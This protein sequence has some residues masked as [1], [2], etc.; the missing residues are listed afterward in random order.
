VQRFLPLS[1]GLI[2]LL[3]LVPA[4]AAEEPD[5]LDL[6]ARLQP[7]P[8]TARLSEPGY[9]VWCGSMVRGDDGKYH[10]FYSHWP[11]RLGFDAWVSH[12]EICHAV[13]DQ[14]LGPYQPKDVALPPRGKE[15]WDG[16]CTHDPT[17]MKFGSKY[18][19]Y[20]MGNTS[21]HP[22]GDAPDL[23][24]MKTERWVY[25]NN[26]RVG[27]AVADDPN[28]PWTRFDQPLIAPTPGFVDALCCND[29]TVTARPGGGYLMIY[30]AVGDK[31][32]LP[33]GGPVVHVVATSD[34]PTG[35]F[36]KE[37]TPVFLKEGASFPAEDP[38]VFTYR[39]LY[40]TLLKDQGGYYTDQAGKGRSLVLFESQDGLHWNLAKHPF[41]SPREIHW[42]D[43]HTQELYALERPQLWFENGEPAILFCA[44]D[45]STH[46]AESFNVHIPLK[47]PDQ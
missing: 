15:F 38:F 40:W 23:A 6:H 5:D 44:A 33:F 31:N 26:Q 28:G 7:A 27:V 16:L 34:S 17:V 29:A 2:V 30:K 43:G 9:Y 10:L 1:L 13:S 11:Q 42:A 37:P 19:L 35:P 22:M 45:G 24:V 25:R 41:V 21:D 20:Y 39:G 8:L 46:R 12:S 4:L 47:K 18:Y 3:L 14:P 32:P 36:K